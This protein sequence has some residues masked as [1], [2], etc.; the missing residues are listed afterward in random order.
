MRNRLLLGFFLVCMGVAGN[1]FR[2]PLFFG[3]DFVF[4]S[5]ATVVAIIKLGRL[6]GV[7]VAFGG[8]A[9]TIILWQ[10]PYAMIIFVIEALFLGVVYPRWKNLVLADVVFW[11]LVGTPLVFAFYGVFLQ[12]DAVQSQ[13]IA[14]K[15]GLNGVFNALSATLLIFAWRFWRQPDKTFKI[16][17]LIQVS[18]FTAILLPALVLIASE[19]RHLK[20]AL[21]KVV[22]EKLESIADIVTEPAVLYVANKGE[23]ALDAT[24]RQAM[25]LQHIGSS[26]NDQNGAVLWTGGDQTI[27]MQGHIR[28]LGE[29]T[30]I[31]LPGDEA[32][33]TMSRWKAAK[34]RL[35]RPVTS[36]SGQFTLTLYHD[37]AP[38]IH[39]LHRAQVRS[40]LLLAA[41][42]LLAG[43]LAIVIGRSLAGPI[44]HLA[45]ITHQMRESIERGRH[46][47][48]PPSRLNEVNQLGADFRNMSASLQSAFS[49]VKAL[50]GSDVLTGIWNRRRALEYLTETI[51][52]HHRYGGHFCIAIYDVDRFKNINDS[53][54]HAIGDRVLVDLTERV[55]SATRDTD[56][57]ARWGGE[58]FLLIF[59]QTTLDSAVVATE[60]IR[61]LVSESDFSYSGHGVTIS[62]G[63]AEY[64]SGDS[65]DQLLE[66]ADRGLYL[67]KN[68]GRNRVC[69]E[70]C[71]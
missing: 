6:P 38:V 36:D 30:A 16:D 46:L 25:S 62:A 45:D 18:T 9:V 29:R 48:I 27:E 52:R 51:Q 44:S 55:R 43:P 57:L 65:V 53:M 1:Y 12:L 61:E 50:A 59:P 24:A 69:S 22:F 11:L 3:V 63:L 54:G 7:I 26:I 41:I 23:Q 4:G 40:M 37:A 32:L 28:E 66:R 13:L 71:S 21:E 64:Y 34:Y 5:V 17:G 33:S 49:D 19:N 56:K 47:S 35:L 20:S 31:W 60:K 58:E 68:A 14:L 67:A 42:T 15:Q 70:A 39:A 2:F 10:H 8:G